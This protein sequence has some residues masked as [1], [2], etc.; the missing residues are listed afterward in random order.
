[1]GL[2]GNLIAHGVVTAARNSTINT[3]GNAAA[4]VI[5]SASSAASKKK[6][7]KDDIM[8]KNGITLI[9]PT[10]SSE[11]YIGAN[12]LDIAQELLGAGFDS[13]KLSPIYKLGETAK[14]KYGK[15][16][17]ISIN[18]KTDF[19]GVKRIPVSSHIVIE[20]L[21]FKKGVSQNA[22]A[23][24]ERITSGVMN[25]VNKTENTLPETNI[26]SN[27]LDADSKQVS[28]SAADEILKFKKLLDDGIITDEEFQTKK[29]QLLTL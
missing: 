28:I 2:I 9:K 1:M 15:I 3:I 18:G 17:S 23:N 25:N 29:K 27:L 6:A 14:K 16:T 5:T 21:E 22:Y 26:T 13:V 24:V 7:E 8:I 20:Y 10:R 12:A 11:E 19:L 4:T